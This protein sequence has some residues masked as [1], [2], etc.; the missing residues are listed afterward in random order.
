MVKNMQDSC[1]EIILNNRRYYYSVKY[2]R[3]KRYHLRISALGVIE[4]TVP[5][6]S[7]SSKIKEVLLI[8]SDWIQKTFNKI[9]LNN[10]NNNFK[11]LISKNEILFLGKNRKAIISDNNLYQYNDDYFFVSENWTYKK[12]FAIY[13]DILISLY[14]QK[15]NNIVN[16]PKL[17][18]KPLKSKWGAYYLK[19]HLIVLNLYLLFFD[20]DI[21]NYVIDHELTHIKHFDHSKE[22]YID[23]Y[24]RCPDADKYRKILKEKTTFI[25]TLITQI[26]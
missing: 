14:N 6:R 8:N 20:K 10:Q 17:V 24:K 12:I 16:K 18:I 2:K 4:I 7:S 11:E 13:Q 5:M 19:K 23:L 3:V 1:N 9:S 15:C 22:F 26:G 21:I 25:N